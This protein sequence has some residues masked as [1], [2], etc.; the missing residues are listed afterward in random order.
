MKHADV[1]ISR[2]IIVH[3]QRLLVIKRNKYGQ[4]YHSFPG[5]KIEA[6][7]SPEQAVVR[8][9][10]EETSVHVNVSRY[11]YRYESPEWGVQ[12]FYICDYISGEP[13]VHPESEEF[14]DTQSG[15]NT[16][17]PMWLPCDKLASV[18][19]YPAEVAVCVQH[20]I[21]TNF[22]SQEVRVIYDSRA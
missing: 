18:D 14:V 22:S 19:L 8:E 21:K 15:N 11:L 20:D 2:A 5:G 13:M 10:L 7:E 16:Y 3:Q 1:E 9:V 17:A 12:D 6:G 4:E